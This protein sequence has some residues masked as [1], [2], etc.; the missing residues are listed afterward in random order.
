LKSE[1]AVLGPSRLLMVVTLGLNRTVVG[2]L[3]TSVGKF[4][5]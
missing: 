5:H 4:T 3:V 1:S 2:A